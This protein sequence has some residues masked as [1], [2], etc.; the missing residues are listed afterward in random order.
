MPRLRSAVPYAVHGIGCEDAQE[1]I[2]DGTAMAARMMDHN[3]KAGKQVTPGNIAY[4]TIQHLKSGRR[5]TGTRV[6]DVLGAG[7]QLHGRARL[8][9]LEEPAIEADTGEELFAIHDVLADEQED[10]SM[11]VARKLDWAAFGE[12]LTERER[13]MVTFLAQGRTLREVAQHFR[14]GD[15]AIQS[16]KRKLAIALLEFMGEDILHRVQ[17]Q[18]QWRHGIHATQEQTHCRYERLSQ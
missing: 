7:T 18:P 17:D 1:L 14:V 13:T 8:H 11:A 3:E 10:P 16:S 9:S 6:V 12:G 2:Q 4:Y 5:S 15:S